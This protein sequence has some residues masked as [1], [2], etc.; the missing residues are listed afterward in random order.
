ME[1]GIIAGEFSLE[2]VTRDIVEDF[3]YVSRIADGIKLTIWDLHRMEKDLEKDLAQ[4]EGQLL[5]LGI[6]YVDFGHQKTY[7]SEGQYCPKY[8]GSS[9]FRGGA[10]TTLVNHE[11]A[12]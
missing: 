4:K 9:Y 11:G 7:H 10:R 2:D 1:Q 12:T 6:A 5:E 3:S 8:G